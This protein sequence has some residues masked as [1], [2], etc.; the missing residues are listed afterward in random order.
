[1]QQIADSNVEKRNTAA[2]ALFLEAMPIA[3]RVPQT[4]P[5]NKL[6]RSRFISY[7]H[8]MVEC[9][10]EDS[11][12]FLPPALLALLHA[13][14]DAADVADV[15]RLVIQLMTK[16]RG[17]LADLLQQLLPALIAR[18][19]SPTTLATFHRQRCLE[20]LDRHPNECV[21]GKRKYRRKAKDKT[22]EFW[23]PNEYF[24]QGARNALGRVGLERC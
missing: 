20:N 24:T 4:L 9:L 22:S 16:F 10:G 21:T 1:M 2:G 14:C 8:R 19:D 5:R 6:L 3:L 7:L 13:E 11:L 18:Y 15:L 23:S 17:Q 12:H